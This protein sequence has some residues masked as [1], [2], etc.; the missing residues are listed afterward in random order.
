MRNRVFL[1]GRIFV[2]VLCASTYM[3]MR[4]RV[5]YAW[6]QIYLINIRASIVRVHAGCVCSCEPF[7]VGISK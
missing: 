7:R 4:K 1:R 2:R 6:K 5:V 3:D